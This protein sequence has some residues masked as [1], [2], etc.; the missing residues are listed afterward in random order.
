MIETEGK[1]VQVYTCVPGPGGFGWRPKGPEAVLTNK[2]GTVV[3]THFAGPSWQ[4]KDGSMVTGEV[5]SSAVGEA[6]AIPWLV[7]RGASHAGRGLFATVTFVVRTRTSG[8]LAPAEGCDGAHAGQDVR[9]PY[10]A[11]YTFFPG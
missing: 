11:A 2:A 4:A 6:G 3:G 1:G 10:T 9:V 7:L 8:G 5:V